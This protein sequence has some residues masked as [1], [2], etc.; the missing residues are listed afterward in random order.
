MKENL[1]LSILWTFPCLLALV[2]A[3][4]QE[5]H[6][7]PEFSPPEV[8]IQR[9]EARTI[10]IEWEFVGQTESS[11]LVEIRTRVEG[12]LDKRLYEEGMLVQKGQVLFQMDDRPFVAALQ[13][14]KGTLAQQEARQQNAQRNVARLK[15]LI[16]QKAVSQKDVDDAVFELAGASAAVLTARA[17]V[18]SAEL[19]LSYATIRSPLTGLSGQARKADGS[20]ISPGQDGLLTTVTQTNP[21]W[22]KFSISETRLL[23]VSTAIMKNQLIMPENN[24]FVVEL[25]LSNG[26]A[27]PLS[28]KM[29]FS[30][31][32]FSTETGT[33]GF[34]ATFANPDTA[35][36]PGQFIRVK[37]KGAI[38]PNA[39]LVPQR[40]VLQGQQGKYLYV[41]GAGNKAEIRP[42]EIGDWYG[43]DWIIES[44]LNSGEQIIVDGMGH[45]IPN[46]PVKPQQPAS[47]AKGDQP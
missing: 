20:F 27:Y 16:S 30:E 24:D 26:S 45:V 44:G 21:I 40:A 12:V 1:R 46:M 32:Q 42:V 35:L 36:V 8:T 22:V 18:T 13:G 4:C 10:P 38:Q 28:G 11:R 43:D 17:G 34:R 41:I 7:A 6:A 29:N 37:L 19:N 5:Q 47:K 3:A 23:K 14:E 2:L 9:I 33:R 31:K 25:Y 39:I 15:N